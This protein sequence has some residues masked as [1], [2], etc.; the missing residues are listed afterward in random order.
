MSQIWTMGNL[1]NDVSFFIS[2]LEE[3]KAPFLQAQ[4]GPSEGTSGLLQGTPGNSM[5]FHLQLVQLME[6]WCDPHL[7]ENSFRLGLC[8]LNRT[9]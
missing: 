4:E 9:R 6:T 2:L 3:Q 8:A 1:V 5:P 7:H